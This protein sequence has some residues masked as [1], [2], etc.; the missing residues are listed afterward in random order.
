MNSRNIRT[1]VYVSHRPTFFFCLALYMCAAYIFHLKIE[2]D[3]H[4]AVAQE[5][6]NSFIQLLHTPFFCER[7]MSMMRCFLARQSDHTAVKRM[8][9]RVNSISAKAPASDTHFTT[10]RATC[11]KLLHKG[12]FLYIYMVFRSKTFHNFS[13]MQN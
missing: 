10:P 12:T 13:Q 4:N 7:W 1:A 6:Y 8:Q 3:S 2:A 9:I 5:T 11:V